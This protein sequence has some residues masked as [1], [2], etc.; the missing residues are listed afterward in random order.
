MDEIPK[1]LNYKFVVGDNP[2]CIWG[3]DLNI[4]NRQF[5]ENISPKHYE[6]LAETHFEKLFKQIDQNIVQQMTN[7]VKKLFVRQQLEETGE[8]YQRRHGSDR[9]AGVVEQHF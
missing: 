9:P 6:Y 2:M 8:I 4:T 3:W 1:L 7:N 5:L